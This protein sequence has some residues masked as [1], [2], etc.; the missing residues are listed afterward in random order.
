MSDLSELRKAMAEKYRRCPAELKP[1]V[2]RCSA[3]GAAVWDS[4]VC[5]E[6]GRFH[7]RAPQVVIG[8]VKV[9]ADERVI[10][11]RKLVSALD[12]A[13]IKWQPARVPV[14]RADASSLNIFQT[15]VL[16]SINPSR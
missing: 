4:K 6:T 14:V 2:Q 16:Q 13:R 9:N 15:F 8:G 3:C 7:E 1:Q 5:A 10:D 11:S 12:A